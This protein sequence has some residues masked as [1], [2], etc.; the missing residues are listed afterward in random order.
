MNGRPLGLYC[1]SGHETKLL[2]REQDDFKNRHNTSTGLFSRL[3]KN[4]HFCGVHDPTDPGTTV[5]V[6][7]PTTKTN[8]I[9][10]SGFFLPYSKLAYRFVHMKSSNAT[11]KCITIDNDVVQY[12]RFKSSDKKQQQ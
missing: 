4:F 6:P 8:P 11:Q 10:N 3:V 9:Q 2:N 7:V 5:P 1:H 12:E